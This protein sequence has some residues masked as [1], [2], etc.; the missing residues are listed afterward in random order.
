LASTGA[1]A[2]ASSPGM[3]QARLA[4]SHNPKGI[5]RFGFMLVFLII[6][7]RHTLCQRWISFSPLPL[8]PQN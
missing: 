1:G 8:K 6:K 3:R 4:S 2:G 5:N 7:I